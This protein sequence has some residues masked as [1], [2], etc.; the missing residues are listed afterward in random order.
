MKQLKN[1]T[2]TVLDALNSGSWETYGGKVTN[3]GLQEGEYVGLP[4]ADSSWNFNT[5]TKDEY[6]TVLEGIRS[7]KIAVDNNSDSTVTPHR[8]CSH[9]R[10]LHRLSISTPRGI[11]RGLSFS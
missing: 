1:V 7:G 10:G 5:F 8:V 6:N 9:Q 11:L 2:M 4:T 3:F